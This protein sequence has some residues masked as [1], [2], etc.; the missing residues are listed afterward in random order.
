[1]TEAWTYQR[2]FDPQ[3]VSLFTLT[4]DVDT[5]VSF[6][7]RRDGK[8]Y[9]YTDEIIL[10][11]NV[12]IATGRPLLV[13]GPS[14][15]GKSTLAQN[16]ARCLRWRYYE[17]V[18]T[19]RLQARDLLWRFDALRRFNDA[20]GGQLKEDIA[21]YI[22]PG[23]LWWA[24]EPESARKRGQPGMA[25][26]EQAFEPGGMLEEG[27]RKTQE[28][29][30][31][32]AAAQPTQKPD[33]RPAVVLLDEIDKADPDVPNNL[34]VPLGS[35]EFHVED[36]G[37]HVRAKK[38]PLIFITT[39]EERQLPAAFLRR[40]IV[41]KLEAPGKERMVEIAQAH[42]GNEREELYRELAGLLTRDSGKIGTSNPVA[43]STAEYLDA[44]R[45]CIR[46]GV[47]PSSP[48]WEII[49]RITLWKPRGPQ[50]AA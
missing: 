44:L 24:F 40:C 43:P 6:A 10:A 48:D 14:G 3:P 16:V 7:D 35:L 18:I 1:M 42:F 22:E 19:S 46:L 2:L 31:G 11:V 12:A 28:P 8:V 39:N 5:P 9:V 34:L 17:E 38:P 33:L 45:T 26:S 30:C 25:K 4:G 15:S 41:V 29:V 13:R 50:G 49:S 32:S 36:L 47:T 23:V 27:V 21:P 37:V 20:Q